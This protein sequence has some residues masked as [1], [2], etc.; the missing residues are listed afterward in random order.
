MAF[1]TKLS[2]AEAAAFLTEYDIGALVECDG[3]TAGSENSNYRLRT[4]SGLYILTLYEKRVRAE[5]LPFFLAL[6][7]HLDAAG[8]RCPKPIQGR[9]GNALR[10]LAKK[11]AA[12]FSFLEGHAV[13][14]PETWHCRALGTALAEMHKACASFPGRRANDLSLMGWQRDFA[15]CRERADT[16]QPGLRDIIEREL[17][18][19]AQHWPKGLPDGVIHADLFPDNVFFVGDGVSG[20]IDFYFACNDFLAYDIAV[21]LNAWCFDDDRTFNFTKGE[22]LLA[23]YGQVRPLGADER[24]HLPVLLRGAAMRFLITRL[25][26][27]LHPKGTTPKD[28]LAYLRR[29]VF[30]Q[31]VKSS[32]L[33]GLA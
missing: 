20:L 11:R 12:I 30:H 7:Q 3:I 15:K 31:S 14:V 25:Y 19:L 23:A 10:T 5:D 17:E 32:R 18:H 26:D 33:Y 1:F 8:I 27:K 29:L 4:T 24:S 21:C 9:G 2:N 13:N 28:P 22:R 6:M 16:V